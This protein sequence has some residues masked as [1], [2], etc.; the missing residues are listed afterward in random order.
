ML[1]DKNGNQVGVYCENTGD[2][3]AKVSDCTL[4]G[5][6]ITSRDGEGIVDI[7]LPGN[8]RLGMTEAELLENMESRGKNQKTLRLEFSLTVGTMNYL[9]VL[10]ELN[11][12]KILRRLL[13]L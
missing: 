12:T 8:V 9:H 2:K 11:L 10:W 13:V 7:A 6:Y 1:K 3:D 4:T 5:F